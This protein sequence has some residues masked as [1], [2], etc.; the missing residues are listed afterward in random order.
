MEPPSTTCPIFDQ[1]ASD[2]DHDHDIAMLEPEMTND[3]LIA[4]LQWCRTHLGWEGS[5]WCVAM[6][7]GDRSTMW[8]FR[9]REDAML[10]Q[11]TWC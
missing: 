9:Y 4:A 5:R 6:L 3:Q 1:W 10:F 7:L 11:L 8:L 2:D